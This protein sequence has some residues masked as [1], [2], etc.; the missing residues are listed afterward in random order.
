MGIP[1]DSKQVLLSTLVTF[2]L[3]LVYT[4]INSTVRAAGEDGP[5][6]VS[7]IKLEYP[8]NPPNIRMLYIR[9][10]RLGAKRVNQPLLFDTGSS[11]VTIDCKVALPR[12]LCSPDGIRI[13]KDTEVNGIFV[14]T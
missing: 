2:V 8:G 4:F 14:T 9:L 11:G 12:E 6:P 13:D 1:R 7:L 10:L 3:I 5:I